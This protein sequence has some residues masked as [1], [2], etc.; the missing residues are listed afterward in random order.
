L[1]P[2][3][4]LPLGEGLMLMP[5][6]DKY[7]GKTAGP[8]FGLTR[9]VQLPPDAKSAYLLCRERFVELAAMADGLLTQ[10][11]SNSA[12]AGCIHLQEIANEFETRLKL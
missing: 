3:V 11:L 6:G 2:R 7:P 10:E 9:H 8:G 5:A 12:K 1:M 4:V